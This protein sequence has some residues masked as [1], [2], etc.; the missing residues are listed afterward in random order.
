MNTE[1]LNTTLNTFLTAFNAGW[2]NLQLAIN[3]LIGT[4]LAIELVLVGLWWALGGGAQLVQVMKKLLYLGF[5][6]WIV[7]NFPFLAKQFVFSLAKA[8]EIAGGAAG[9]QNILLDPSGIINLGLA[10]TAPL[11]EAMVKQGWDIADGITYAVMWL[12]AIMGF[13]II[14]W[15]MFYTVLEFYILLTLVGIILPFGFFEPTKFMAEKSIGAVIS[16]GVK[17]MVLS[18]I[19][20]VST[21]VI[22]GLPIPADIPSI[23]TGITMVMV[24]GAI[25]FLAWNAPGIAAGLVV[26]SP[27]LSASTG[28]QNTVA[29][30]LA[31]GGATVVAASVIKSSATKVASLA[32]RSGSVTTRSGQ[33]ASLAEA[34]SGLDTMP[35]SG[36][37][38]SPTGAGIPSPGT[39]SGGSSSSGEDRN[40][41]SGKKNP[42]KWAQQALQAS[43]H[44]P[45]EARPSGGDSS[46]K[47]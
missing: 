32:G 30:G 19:I 44:I 23:E 47:L 11:A 9:N 17:L 34:S 42:P 10:V 14:A 1:I 43:R 13:V 24:S 29:A 26:G 27:S 41:S 36:G 46:P 31:A 37:Q 25:A 22:S 16:S 4:M 33:M 35:G 3:W 20:A 39:P 40:K 12:L 38:S 21:N 28:V 18:F 15:Q 5:W 6:M 7:T 2:G 45:E 8:G